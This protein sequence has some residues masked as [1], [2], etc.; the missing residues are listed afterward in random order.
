[1]GKIGEEE[2]VLKKNSSNTERITEQ[3]IHRTSVKIS[4]YWY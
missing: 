1:M 2:K 4:F 3:T